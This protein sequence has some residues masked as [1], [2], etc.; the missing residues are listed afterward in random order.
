[1]D[2]NDIISRL[3][4]ETGLPADDVSHFVRELAALRIDHPVEYARFEADALVRLRD[5]RLEGSE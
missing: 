5:Q 2:Y 3:C 4:Q 1:M